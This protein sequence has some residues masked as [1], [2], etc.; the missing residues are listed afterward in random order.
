MNLFSGSHS[1]ISMNNR[2]AFREPSDR[3]RP[4]ASTPG[5]KPFR[6]FSRSVAEHV[7]FLGEYIRN[8]AAVGAFAPSSPKLARAMIEG[9]DLHNAETVVELGPG[10]GAFTGPIL[11]RIGPKTTFFALELSPDYVRRLRT[12]FPDLVLYNDSAE[13]IAAYL[14]RHGRRSVDY[15]ISGLPWASIRQEV[16][17]R[18]LHQLFRVL[19][20]GGVFT[21]FGYLHTRPA[22]NAIHFGRLTRNHFA[23]VKVTSLVWLNVPPALVYRCTK[24]A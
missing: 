9:C 21:T 8:P 10:T 12:R 18:I 19:K 14:G 7:H 1:K 11:D 2:A 4:R 13:H 20:P 23:S 17:D 24:A 15:I 5:P 6:A 16:Q 22:P 3:K